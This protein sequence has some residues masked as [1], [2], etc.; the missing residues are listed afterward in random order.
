MT[1]LQRLCQLAP[2]SPRRSQCTFLR[3]IQY[4]STALAEGASERA[5]VVR[6]PLSLDDLARAA[7]GCRALAYVYKCDAEKQSNPITRS[8]LEREIKA[9]EALAE[10]FDRARAA[11]SE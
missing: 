9:L 6:M 11:R 7:T 10:R 5:T 1:A 4:R 3:G 2:R 8:G